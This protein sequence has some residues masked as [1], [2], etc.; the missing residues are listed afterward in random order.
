MEHALLVE[1][2]EDPGRVFGPES[3]ARLERD[4]ECGALEV[5][6]QQMQVVGIHEA[7][8][9]RTLEHVLRMLDDVLVD[10]GRGG[11]E[12]GRRQILAPPGPTHLLPRRGDRSGIAKK[13]GGLKGTDVDAELERVRRDDA[14]DRTVAQTLLDGAPLGWEVATAIAA[15]KVSRP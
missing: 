9:R 8:L 6:H 3:L 7:G 12:E 10:R 11:D 5:M 14:A 2:C 13:H 1:V 15:D 4:L